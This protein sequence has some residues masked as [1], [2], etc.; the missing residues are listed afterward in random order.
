MAYNLLKTFGA[1]IL[2]ISKNFTSYPSHYKTCTELKNVRSFKFDIK[3][4]KKF[5]KTVNNFKPD[6]IFHLAAQALVK[7]SLDRPIET[8][9]SNTIGTLN[10][11]EIFETL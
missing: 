11:L 6:F 5:K 8:W 10:L 2:G 1:K 9:S 3:D 7:K 4:F